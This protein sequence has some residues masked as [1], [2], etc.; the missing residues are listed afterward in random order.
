MPDSNIAFNRP[1]RLRPRW[2]AETV[3]LP[4]PPNPPPPRATTVWLQAMLPVIAALLLG[5][6]ALAGYGSWLAA[7]PALVLAV[8]SS[9]ITLINERNTTQRSASEYAEQ[10]ALFADRL[11]AARARLRRLH[12]TE[13]A[14]R[15]YLAPDPAELLRIAGADGRPRAP[16]P[17]LWERRLSDDDALELRL[18]SGILPAASRAVIPPG[19]PADRQIDQLITEY[20][21]LHQVPICLPL[22][23]LGSLGIAG[24]RSAV[25]GLAYALLAQAATLHAPS[26]LRIALIAHPKAAADWQWIARLP[27]CQTAGEGQSGRVLAAIDPVTTE[28]LLAHLLDELSRR[29]ESALA[30]RAPI[31]IIVDSA[32]LVATYTALG[33]LLRDGGAHGLIV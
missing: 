13:R 29:R 31:V 2:S 28:R 18:G 6:G 11:A 5:A 19:A 9:G 16:E 15:R 20:A 27:H 12:E 30:N 1:P 22:L 7:L 21:T 33:Q 32:T 26:E 17:R 23:R 24:P 14:A 4:V 3:E 25:V 10:R 8:L